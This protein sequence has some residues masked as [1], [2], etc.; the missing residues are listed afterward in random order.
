MKVL[1]TGGKGQLASAIRES[2][3]SFSSLGLLFPEKTKFDIT[4][5]AQMDSF[6]AKEKIDCIVN[7]AAFKDVEKA[8]TE[9]ELAFRI[10]GDGAGNLAELTKKR[11]VR[12]IHVSTDFVFDGRKNTPYEETDPTGPLCVY[13][14]SKLQ[15]EIAALEANPETLIIRTSWLYSEYGRNFLKTMFNAVSSRPQA[16]VVFDQVGTPTNAH[17]VAFAICRILADHPSGKG[18][19]HFSNEGV[20]SWYDFACA[21]RSIIKA[22]CAVEP[23]TSDQYPTL[24]RRPSY[25]VLNK[26]K[27]KGD[28]NLYVP[29]WYESLEQ[30]IVNKF[31]QERA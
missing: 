20:C 17:D 21:I 19:Y 6:L 23:I 31:R 10:N 18:I 29:Y 9:K 11:S 7:C 2:E 25:S 26:R 1:V 24:A 3:K 30:C 28:F 22:P 15:G 14:K 4:R 13:G 16:R 12:Y 8:E 5:I 27:I